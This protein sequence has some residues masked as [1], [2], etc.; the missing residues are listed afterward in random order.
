MWTAEQT[1]KWAG[2]A[3]IRSSGGGGGEGEGAASVRQVGHSRPVPIT[4]VTKL[5]G[6][7]GLQGR[8]EQLSPG[9]LTREARTSDLERPTVGT[10]GV[11]TGV[12]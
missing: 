3:G 9:T 10:A 11:Y 6:V 7:R 1:S 5:R 12:I 8:P 2:E 4:P